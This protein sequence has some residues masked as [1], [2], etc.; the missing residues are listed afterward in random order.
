MAETIK[1]ETRVYFLRFA[2]WVGY[3]LALLGCSESTCIKAAVGLV[4]VRMRA[5]T[6]S[7]RQIGGWTWHRLSAEA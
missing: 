5:V 7:G 6:E 4:V 2:Q 1:I 3:A